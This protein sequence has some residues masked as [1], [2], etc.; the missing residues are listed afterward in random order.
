MNEPARKPVSREVLDQAKRGKVLALVSLGC[1]R[2]MA[3]AKVPCA[4]TTIGRTAARD[5]QFAAALA[6]AEC[7]P[8]R[9]FRDLLRQAN[10]RTRRKAKCAR[11]T[12]RARA[13]SAAAKSLNCCWGCSSAPVRQSGKGTLSIFLAV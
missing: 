5:Q 4:H 3:A 6:E 10:R 1:S 13:A 11:E 12:G 8:Q 2:R 9:E 7:Q